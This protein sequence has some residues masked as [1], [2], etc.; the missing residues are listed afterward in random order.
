MSKPIMF[1]LQYTGNAGPM[2]GTPGVM[3]AHLEASIPAGSA[4]AKAAG[5][6]AGKASFDSV[7][8]V[9]GDGTFLESGT[10]RFGNRGAAI[11]F[12]TAGQGAIGPSADPKLTNG[13]IVWKIVGGEGKLAGATGY[14]TSNFT[15]DAK[16]GVVDNQ[17]TV[18]VPKRK[19]R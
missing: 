14:I 9:T 13:A 8:T 4:I 2:A 1:T 12:S 11:S 7:V 15:V 18:I 5:I 19:K 6:K 3:K 16:G 17:T 10:I